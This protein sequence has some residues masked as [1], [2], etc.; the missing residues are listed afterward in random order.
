MEFYELRI[1]NVVFGVSDPK[2]KLFR[3][4][5]SP[6]LA[7]FM[8]VPERTLN[9]KEVMDE[10]KILLVNLAHSDSL[11]NENARV[12]GA[13]LVNEFFEHARR[14]KKDPS[15]NDLK[16]YYLYIDEFQDFVS[17]DLAKMLDRVRKRG[18][19][20]VMA[21]QRFGQ[22]D[23]DKN[24]TDA[25]LTHCHIT[26]LFRSLTTNSAPTIPPAILL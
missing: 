5:T 23:D 9:L 10:G 13:L 20:L 26:A 8:G 21:H 3:L 18:L 16:P 15:G 25:V 19:F 6:T 17:I 12:F 24:I 11:S 1:G 7:R 22:F 2:N 14:R 4:L